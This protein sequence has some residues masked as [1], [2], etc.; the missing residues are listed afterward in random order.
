MREIKFRAW[1]KSEQE[2]VDWPGLVNDPDNWWYELMSGQNEE[3]VL[4]QY[5]GLKDRNGVD[6]YEGDIVQQ[7]YSMGGY[8][9]GQPLGK[10]VVVVWKNDY[11]CYYPFADEGMIC[12]D[13]CVVVGNIYENNSMLNI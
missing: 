10:P 9:N 8:M 11:S 12:N 13:N 1:D 5:T 3:D 7:V 2:M 6:I 4:M